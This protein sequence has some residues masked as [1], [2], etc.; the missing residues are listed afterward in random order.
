ML[1]DSQAVAWSN[2]QPS[3]SELGCD[4]KISVSRNYRDGH[5][6][7]IRIHYGNCVRKI[8]VHAL[9][10]GQTVVRTILTMFAN[11]DRTWVLYE[12]PKVLQRPEVSN[13]VSVT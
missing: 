9:Q 4:Q 12:G 7:Q 5:V 8:P 6:C 3:P 2:T 10:D 1:P 11:A 13:S